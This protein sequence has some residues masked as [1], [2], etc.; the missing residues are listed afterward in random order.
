MKFKA[1]I[2]LAVAALFSDAAH[3]AKLCVN[4]LSKD[5]ATT[6]N[7]RCGQIKTAERSVNFP[8][9]DL[10][11]MRDDNPYQPL[12][13]CIVDTKSAAEAYELIRLAATPG[14]DMLLICLAPATYHPVSTAVTPVRLE[15]HFE[16]DRAKF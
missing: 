11:A 4:Q 13:Q 15:V 3:A 7:I 10:I 8:K 1:L 16:Q 12:I 6:R 9:V 5:G 14:D 2:V